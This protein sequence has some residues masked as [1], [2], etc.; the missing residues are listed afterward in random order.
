MKH[1]GWIV[2][3]IVGLVL[4]TG[5]ALMYSGGD[6]R[7]AGEAKRLGAQQLPV[8]LQSTVGYNPGTLPASTSYGQ[9]F[10]NTEFKVDPNVG[11]VKIQHGAETYK[12]EVLALS[13]SSYGGKGSVK[14]RVN[15]EITAELSSGDSFIL[16]NGKKLVLTKLPSSSDPFIRGYIAG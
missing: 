5:L 10:Q 1:Y 7:T 3:A 4:A 11:Y 6:L 13:T 16:I 14:F 2:F 8:P 15:G 9:Q 12:I